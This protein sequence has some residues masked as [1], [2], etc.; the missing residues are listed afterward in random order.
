ML[1]A[2]APTEGGP[3]SP[4]KQAVRV[5]EGVHTRSERAPSVHKHEP[6][7][8][9]HKGVPG[10]SRDPAAS[11]LAPNPIRLAPGAPTGR[12]ARASREEA[13]L[14]THAGF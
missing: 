6:P 13:H 4:A 7:G 5:P 1:G 12:C 2:A 11:A 3:G 8:A 9:G 10:L 14:C